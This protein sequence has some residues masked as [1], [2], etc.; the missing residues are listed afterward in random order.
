MSIFTDGGNR[1]NRRIRRKTPEA[2]E[3][4]NNKLNSHI[5]PDFSGEASVLTATPPMLPIECHRI[6]LALEHILVFRRT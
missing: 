5:T 2:R 4:I 3:I 6:N 1:E